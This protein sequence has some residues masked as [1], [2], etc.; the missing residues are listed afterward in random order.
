M[1]KTLRILILVPLQMTQGYIVIIKDNHSVDW[2][3]NSPPPSKTPPLFFVKPPLK[4]AKCL[5]PL[6]RKPCYILVF[7][8]PP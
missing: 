1:T 2:V 3:I 4:S 6:F 7:H 8:D 5:S